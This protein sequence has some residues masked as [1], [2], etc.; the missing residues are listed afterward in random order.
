MLNVHSP[1]CRGLAVQRLACEPLTC[2]GGVCTAQSS[3]K[4]I[5]CGGI[6]PKLSCRAI[7]KRARG[8]RSIN[9]RPV[10]SNAR[11][12]AA[13]ARGLREVASRVDLG[14]ISAINGAAPSHARSRSE[15]RPRLAYT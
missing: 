15:R 1:T 9:G 8:A 12:A 13:A 2:V 3:P 14:D 10:C 11:Y 7:S 4:P 5:L 6:T